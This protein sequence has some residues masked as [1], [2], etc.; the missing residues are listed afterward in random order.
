MDDVFGWISDNAWLSWAAAGGVLTLIE[1]LSLDLVFLMFAFG[2]FVAALVSA[3]GAPLWVCVAVFGVVSIFMLYVA[4]PSMARRL[5]RGPTLTV[6]HQALVGHTAIA[7]T[8]VD[9]RGGRVMLRGESWSARA[10]EHSDSFQ[11]DTELTVTKI[12]GATAIV[13]RKATS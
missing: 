9:V 1:L 3:V 5:H 6:G 2:A 10:Q 7:Q 12:D 11:P 4:R 13:T 8:I